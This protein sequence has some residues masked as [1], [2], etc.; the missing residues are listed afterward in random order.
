M[1]VKT[2][3]RFEGAPP[4]FS[5]MLRGHVEHRS[6]HRYTFRYKGRGCSPSAE[7]GSGCAPGRRPQAV[8]RG[9][10]GAGLFACPAGGSRHFGP[11]N[12]PRCRA[13]PRGGDGRVVPQGPQ[14]EQP[15]SPGPHLGKSIALAAATRRNSRVLEPEAAS[16]ALRRFVAFIQDRPEL[17]RC[18][19]I[20]PRMK[21]NF[22]LRQ[23]RLEVIWH[24]SSTMAVMNDGYRGTGCARR[25]VIGESCWRLVRLAAE[26][27]KALFREVRPLLH[28]APLRCPPLGQQAS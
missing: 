12:W 25:P 1:V 18:T 23:I 22:R 13:P 26:L 27:G 2:P 10:A 17:R 19:S 24:R 15:P 9:D 8:R 6:V 28:I 3:G 14:A 21:S 11:Y 20:A 5:C 4:S 16:A 7:R